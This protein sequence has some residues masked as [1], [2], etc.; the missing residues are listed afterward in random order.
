MSHCTK[1]DFKY[2]DERTIVQ[3]FKKL[4]IPCSTEL[5]GE[6]H[7]EIGKRVLGSIGYAGTKQY[8]AICGISEPYQLF[9]CKLEEHHYELVIEKG[10][11]ITS[12]DALAMDNLSNTFQTAYIGVAVDNL[13]AK[14]D[15]SNMPAKV[16]RRENQYIVRFGPSY[17]YSVS[18]VFDSNNIIEDVNGIQGE[19]C[20]KLTEDI[21][22]VLSHPLAEL[23]TE[24][25][26]DV[27]LMVED[28]NIQVLELNF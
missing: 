11:V 16:E 27:N 21:E 12:A 23:N 7:T 8:R 18:I 3:T 26:E 22:N 24:W 4:N 5:I 15:K 13:V 6:F 1:F 9:V 10:G 25:K 14:L 2:S 28:T 19:F 17:E 20:T